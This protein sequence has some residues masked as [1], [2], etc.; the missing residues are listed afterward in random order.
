ERG[1]DDDE[2]R[3][4]AELRLLLSPGSLLQAHQR[5]RAHHAEAPRV[6]R[7]VVW[8]PACQLEELIESFAVNRLGPK[9]LMCATGADRLFNIH[10][11]RMAFEALRATN[12]SA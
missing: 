10:R 12:V 3:R 1:A 8:R 11:L 5:A 4:A 9:G 2:R 7:V 6:G